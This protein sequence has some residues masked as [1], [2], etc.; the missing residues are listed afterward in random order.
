MSRV[1]IVVSLART[2]VL[3]AS[4]GGLLLGP[5]MNYG[6]RELVPQLGS[7]PRNHWSWSINKRKEIINESWLGLTNNY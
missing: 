5:R 1:L 2:V 7:L 4:G 3:G 6:F